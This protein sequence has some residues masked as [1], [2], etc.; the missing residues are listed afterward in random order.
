MSSGPP[1]ERSG[2]PPRHLAA[3]AHLTVPAHVWKYVEGAVT[4]SAADL[5]MLDL[6]DAMPGGDDASLEVG[7]RNIGRAM[8]SLDW[9]SRLRFFRPRGSEEDPAHADIRAVV[10][11]CAG[12]L[13]GL[14][15]PKVDHPDEVRAV[16]ATLTE[17]EA[18]AG[19]AHGAVRLHVL[20]ESAIAEERAFEIAAAS[21]RITGIVFGAFDYFSSLGM[22]G[23]RYRRDHPLVEGARLRI[24]RAAA[25]VGAVAIAEMTLEFPTRDKTPAEQEAALAACRRDAEHAREL[26]FW[27]KWVGIPAQ[28]EVV[29]DVFRL[30]PAEIERSARVVEAFMAAERAGRGAVMI[31]GKMADRATV[32]MERVLLAAAVALGL[33]DEG[34]AR[35]LRAI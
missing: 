2:V 33:L 34:R 21:P 31:D 11:A 26:G 9:G 17:L 4:K 32:R 27:G 14:V 23:V 22:R 3:R 8:T 19:L 12:K 20:I 24:V 10:P 13:E 15:L 7:R 30:D 28:A 25:S 5:V 29:R 1:S 35:A 6:E 18:A 16:D